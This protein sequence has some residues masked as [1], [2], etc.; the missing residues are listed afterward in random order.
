MT[1]LRD[2]RLFLLDMDGTIYIGD[3]LF[4][5]VPEFLRH[6]RAMG[7]R[8]LFLT[9]NSSRGVEGYMEK[10]RRMGIETTRDDY[11]TSVD[12][13]VRYLRETLPGKTCYVFGTDSFLAQLDGAGIPVTRDREQ[14]EVLLCGFDTELTFQ[15]LE[16]ACIL[17]N[18]G[19]PFV[20]TN[21]DWVCPTWYGSVPDCGSVCRMLTTATGREPTVIG[22][23][24]PQ[25]ALLAMERTGFS[26]EQTVL[27][28]DRLY[29]DVACGVNAGIDTV[30]V[31][32]GHGGHRHLPD[33]PH[34]G[35][36]RHRYP[37]PETGGDCM[38]LNYKRT[39]FVGFAF[40]LICSFWQAYDNTIPL[41]LTNKFGMSQAWSGVIM[42]LDNVLALFM[43]PLFGAIS[44]KHRGKRGRRTPFIVVGT[45]IAAVM[46]IALSFVDNAQLR[47]LSDVSA[48]D[49]PAALEQIY[50]RQ[51]GETLLTPS[52]DKFVLSQKF[53]QEE[54]IRIRSQVEQDGKTVTNPDYTNYVVPARQACAWDA[55]AKSPATLVFFIVL[56][57][58][59]LVSMA[60]FRSPAVA[61]M[62]DVTLKPLRSKANA[63]INLMGSAGGILV[64]A[65][66]MVFA[67]SA[68]R[69]SL[70]SYT[71]YF[72]VIAAIML[73][74]LV[75]F[76]LTVREKE[77][78]YE[79]Q[80]QAVA[81]GIEEETQAQEEAA[82]G[83]KLSVDE[84]KSLIFLLL[85][86]V[87]W[88]FGYNAVTSKYSVY[89]S[90]ILH[91][92]YNLTLIIAQAAA[93]VSYLPVGFIASK[94]GRKKTILAGV[95]MLTTAFTVAAFLDAESPT[96]LMNAMFA[97]AG[98][99]W[100]TIN[101]NSFPMVVEMCS[102]GDVG[103]YTGFYYTASMAA[104]V[105]T[106]MLSGLLMDRF[107]MH[108][109]FPYAAVFT[110]LA[111]VTMLF[112]RHG[113]SK[114]Q[115]KIGLEA[116]DEMED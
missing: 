65:L 7:G 114:P 32:S 100:A 34:L 67:T 74:A 1:K 35:V 56:L 58:I 17:L 36:S 46:L 86:I 95:V 66:G 69:N 94:A 31:L 33:P 2:K 43:L 13:T 16:D 87:L 38:K 57:L 24:R 52:G 19:V 101:V 82:G 97:L 68:V 5:G 78:A 20:A 88:F 81:L 30:F 70:M 113:D 22:K 50:D 64:L 4:D 96:M 42:A 49:D 98:I 44:D 41:I 59:V 99:A 51:A 92:D 27:L 75:I 45:L 63:V 39:I 53:T 93:I 110:T 47:H 40:F 83:R 23:P 71:G 85:S 61:L 111:F 15:K 77:W 109:L 6:V 14:A 18:R 108:V 25:M 8:Y 29:T 12:A 60:V 102:G 55:T 28:G 48:I 76:M 106:P 3:R 21:P 107:G 11:L 104:Q 10:L 89:A 105:A 62:P 115:A 37:V 54:F 103:K 90:N 73:S 72:A 84:V 26:P 9:N 91:K 80:Q 116:L 79:M 112:V